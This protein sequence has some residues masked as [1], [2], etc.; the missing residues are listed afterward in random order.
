MTIT[1]GELEKGIARA[2]AEARERDAELLRGCRDG[3][4]GGPTLRL[5]GAALLDRMVPTARRVAERV[6]LVRT[7]GK[8][9]YVRLTGRSYF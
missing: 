9:L 7:F 3:R 6:P 2:L 1:I 4:A 8:W 5:R